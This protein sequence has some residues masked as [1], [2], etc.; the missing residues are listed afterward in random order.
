MG[1]NRVIKSL[2][3]NVGRLVVHKILEK[4]TNNLEAIEH[5]KHEITAYRENTKEIAEEYN[6]SEKNK[7]EIALEAIGEFEKEMCRDYP[8]VKFPVEEAEKLV[9]DTLNEILE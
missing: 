3:K 4:Y 9:E 6:W 1:K 2:G 7:G 8:D 5:L